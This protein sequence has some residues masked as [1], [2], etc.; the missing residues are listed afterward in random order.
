M[1]CLIIDALPGIIN[2]VSQ[3]IES[4]KQ[5][6]GHEFDDTA[7]MT[8]QFGCTG[9]YLAPSD[10]S[11]FLCSVPT[12]RGGVK[13]TYTDCMIAARCVT[14][15]SIERLHVTILFVLPLVSQVINA[16]VRITM[17]MDVE[18]AHDRWTAPM[19]A[20]LT[21]RKTLTSRHQG[22]YR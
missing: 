21:S 13:C 5:L 1:V 3:P 18:T 8:A 4:C 6:Q 10:V 20:R 7:S 16:H 14:S 11:L 22:R 9:S 19:S 2:R 15:D 17:L 12:P